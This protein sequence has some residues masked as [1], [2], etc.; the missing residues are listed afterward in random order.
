MGNLPPFD[1]IEAIGWAASAFTVVTYAMNTM[2]LLRVFAI[3]ST[4]CFL[5]YGIAL[6]V[7]PL[8]AMEV[9]LLPIN[10]YRFWQVLSLRRGIQNPAHS[11]SEFDV[12]KRYGKLQTAAAQE[13]IF[14][15]GDPVDS[16]YYLAEGQVVIE[17]LG[18]T[19]SA[20]EIFGEIA[21]FTDAATR[22]ATVRCVEPAKVYV[23]D[24]KQ[25]MRLQFEDPSFG[26]SVMRTITR[27]L[28]ENGDPLLSTSFDAS[29]DNKGKVAAS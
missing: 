13:I 5:T 18:I 28:M 9:V 27:R 12:I 25:F 8:V 15:R 7:W 11:D 2:L 17:D 24:K 14:R 20:G 3:A 19:L 6:Q 10:L 23:L 22:M 21:F 16:L 4:V 1:V 29:Q 26:L